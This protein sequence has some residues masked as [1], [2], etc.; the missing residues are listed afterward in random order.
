[1][2][3]TILLIVILELYFYFLFFETESCSI[4]KAG[5]QWCYLGSLQPPPPSSNNSR[6]SASQVAWIT[7]ICHHTLLIFVFL[8]ETSFHHV[9]QADLELLTSGNPSA[10]VSQSAGITGRHEPPCLTTWLVLDH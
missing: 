4:A 5:V 6:A 9:V 10:S 7:G 3:Y 8:V 1:M 2:Y